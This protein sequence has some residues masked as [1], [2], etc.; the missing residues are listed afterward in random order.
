MIHKRKKK[1]KKGDN[2]IVDYGSNSEP[3]EGVIIETKI[4]GGLS[5][6][7]VTYGNKTMDCWLQ[8]RFLTKKQK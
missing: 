6:V 8:N 5:K 1:L 4:I 7:K 2:V 3:R